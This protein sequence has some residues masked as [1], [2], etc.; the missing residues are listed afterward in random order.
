[1]TTKK[2]KNGLV[3]EYF[4]NGEVESKQNYKNGKLDGKSVYW[5]ENGQKHAEEHYKSGKLDGKTVLW[6]ENSQKHAEIHF[7]AG[8]KD[9]K[10]LEWHENGQ[11][12][13]ESFYKN[14][15][16]DGKR[17]WW[18]EDGQKVEAFYKNGKVEGKETWWHENGQKHAEIHFKAGKKD[19]KEL[20][21]HENGQKSGE[22]FYK[23]DKLDGKK[24]W[25]HENGQK[26]EEG[27][28]KNG[29]ADG[30]T[31][32]WYESGQ[33]DST[34]N[35]KGGKEYGMITFWHANGQKRAQMELKG[36]HIKVTQWHENGNIANTGS[37]SNEKKEDGGWSDK[38]IGEWKWW[39]ENGALLEE[40]NYKNF[41]LH[42][43]F[44][45]YN[46]KEQITL[47]K[48]YKNGKPLDDKDNLFIDPYSDG[49]LIEVALFLVKSMSD[50]TYKNIDIIEDAGDAI[51][52]L[53]QYL[54]NQHRFDENFES[55]DESSWDK[56]GNEFDALIKII[57]Y[58]L[59]ENP[60]LENTY[61]LH[62][63][64]FTD[65]ELGI[66]HHRD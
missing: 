43:H 64:S 51:F 6:H 54:I 35:Y 60:K 55:D 11:K 7:K 41:V 48:N 38:R 17:N 9:G 24:T 8:K 10:E 61:F 57:Q 36:D 33:I 46:N 21:W 30:T 45:S 3:V 23:N 2:I 20:E 56:V 50:P 63:I 66:D 44:T 19:G 37:T 26:R 39:D 1:M 31:T 47:F 4:S 29:L 5:H 12:S 16:L 42:G 13:G 22:S 65:E 34:T 62:D 27:L 52:A 32:S 28:Y 14:D 25:W 40:A 15:K 18:F 59:F 58:R 53:K 49:W